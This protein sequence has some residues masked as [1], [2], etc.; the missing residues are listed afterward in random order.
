MDV[1]SSVDLMEFKGEDK[2]L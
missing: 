2:R 1:E